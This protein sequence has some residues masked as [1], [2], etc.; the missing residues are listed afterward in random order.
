METEKIRL[1][2]VE[3]DE[4]FGNALF[5]R[6]IKN[7]FEVVT[8]LS[9]EKAL[10]LSEKEN[11]DI[12]VAD[13]KLPGMNGLEFLS[14]IR[15]KNNDIPVILLTGY[16]NIESA[17]EAI[18]LNAADYLLKPLEGIDELLNPI[19]KALHGYDLS[20]KNK[21]LTDTLRSKIKELEASGEELRVQKLSLEQKNSAL[22]ELLEQ[23]EIEK[24]RIKND[25][26]LNLDKLV[27]PILMK[28]EKRATSLEIKHIKLLRKNLDELALSF[29]RKITEE[30]L[31]LSPREIEICNMIRNGLISKEISQF[32]NL[33]NQTVERHR[34]NI[35]RKLNIVNKDV[36]LVSFLQNL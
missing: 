28:L 30:S 24:E 5:L 23:I 11:F 33:S 34:N 19:H 9:A 35:R 26:H 17:A 3:D 18:K 16:A 12:I 21:H 4:D 27:M 15:E 6:L 22:R 31:S 29:G 20:R 1:L 13:I 36:N 2:L 14:C 25:I 32:L 8:A 7:G 10:A